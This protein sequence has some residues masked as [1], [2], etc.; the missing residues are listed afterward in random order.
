MTGHGTGGRQIVAGVNGSA[1][2]EAAARWAAAVAAQWNVPLRLV[3]VLPQAPVF[4]GVPAPVRD[5]EAHRVLGDAALARAADIIRGEQ[6]A[7]AI[8]C[9]TMTGPT[10]ADV[11]LDVASSAS[12][13]AIGSSCAGPVEG[14]L[15][16]T[17]LRLAHH[18]ECPVTVWRQATGPAVPDRWPVIVGVDGSEISIAAVRWACSFAE[19][20]AVPVVAVHT[21]TGV[22]PQGD[23]YRHEFPVEAAESVL[24][25]ESVAGCRT[26]YPDVTIEQVTE[27]GT[28]ADALLAR[29]RQAQLL[30]VG[31]H[32]RG[33]LG[34]AL[35]GSTSQ[36][37]LHRAHCPVTICRP[38]TIPAPPH[39]DAPSVPTD[40]RRTP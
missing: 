32:G 27:R 25:A 2:A 17:A 12:M 36:D 29:C 33:A 11:L 30:V 31:S 35:L 37:M 38:D 15:N 24:L 34:R 28:P 23:S 19:S 39:T 13:V 9:T 4:Y 20:F 22:A 40:S 10:P 7:A 18:A 3:H 8:E 5:I 1:V 16:A 6:P 21:W 26:E 14:Y